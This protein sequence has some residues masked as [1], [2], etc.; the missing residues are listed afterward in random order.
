MRYTC[1]I[2][3]KELTVHEARV[4]AIPYNTVW[5]GKQRPLDQTEEAYFVSFDISEKTTLCVDI[6]GAEID[7]YA[8][9]PLQFNVPC[10]QES[11]RLIIEI[12][13]PMNFTVEINGF[14]TRSTSLQIRR[15]ISFPTKTLC[16]SDRASTTRG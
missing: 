3:N 11:N 7:K 15:T 5:P 9:R 10:R 6:K 2:E 1:F 12:E 14:H 4:S 13:K 8:I 16:I